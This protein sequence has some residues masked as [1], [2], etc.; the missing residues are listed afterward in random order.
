MGNER[1]Q[2]KIRGTTARETRFDS[3]THS[4]LMKIK[5]P[6]G[7]SS[8]MK[9]ARGKLQ[10]GIIP[11]RLNGVCK[12]RSN[13]AKQTNNMQALRTILKRNRTSGHFLQ[14]ELTQAICQEA[15]LHANSSAIPFPCDNLLKNVSCNLGTNV[16]IESSALLIQDDKLTTTAGQKYPENSHMSIRDDTSTDVSRNFQQQYSTTSLVS[17]LP[18][19]ES[20]TN[21]YN[22]S[23]DQVTAE[24]SRELQLQSKDEKSMCEVEA[25]NDISKLVESEEKHEKKIL[26]NYSMNIQICPQTV[27]TNS[28]VATIQDADL[29][30]NAKFMRHID[31]TRNKD[32]ESNCDVTS[33]K[34]K[35]AIQKN[36]VS[37]K[38]RAWRPAGINKTSESTLSLIPKIPS[39]GR[40]IAS[41]KSRQ[42]STYSSVRRME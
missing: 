17:S 2:T 24:N 7:R 15:K 42:Q 32:I 13:V 5:E 27:Q 38:Q 18:R 34:T 14:N 16:S 11:S 26:E 31:G 6:I 19:T 25:L 8:S 41:T 22:N 4:S 10:V 28:K 20:M 29:D 23:E 3:H 33:N 21:I 12:T 36:L 1:L 9:S 35:C 39:S 40:Y 37:A 30:R